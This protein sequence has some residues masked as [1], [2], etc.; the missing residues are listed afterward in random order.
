MN[1]NNNYYNYVWSFI[2]I[3]AQSNITPKKLIYNPP[4]TICYFEDDTKEIVKCMDGEPFSEEVGAMACIVKRVTKN[5][6]FFMKLVK[7][8]YHQPQ[9]KND[10]E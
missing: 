4:Y 5:H 8:G 1:K 2:N 10:K 3:V 6:S 9:Q 7:N